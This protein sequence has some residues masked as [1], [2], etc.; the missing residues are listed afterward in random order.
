VTNQSVLWR[1]LDLPGHESARLSSQEDTWHLSGTAVFAFNQQPC[2]LDYLVICDSLW[3]TVLGKVSGWVGGE[4]IEIE[5]TVDSNLRWQVNGIEYP[6][7]ASCVDLDLNFSPSTNLLPVRR[8]NLN[9]GEEAEVQAAWLRFPE[10]TLEPLSQVYRRVAGVTYRYESAGG[11]FV[12]ELTV[13]ETGFVV[14][15]PDFWRIEG[16]TS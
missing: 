8:L 5:V 14:E 1:R 11:A 3:R 7:A 16:I 6:E 12:R 2:R 9:V 13:S 15:Y 4:T 10:F